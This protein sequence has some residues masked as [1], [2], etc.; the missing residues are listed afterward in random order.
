MSDQSFCSFVDVFIRRLEETA[1]SFAINDRL[2]HFV[3]VGLDHPPNSCEPM[4]TPTPTKAGGW[5]GV[6]RQQG[7]VLTLG[8]ILCIP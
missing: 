4:I 3:I 6:A 1:N 5:D 8:N 7:V 2:G